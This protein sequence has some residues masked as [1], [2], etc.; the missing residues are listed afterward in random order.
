MGGDLSNAP[1]GVAP[2]FLIR[3]LRDP[4]G[5]NLDRVQ[6]VKGWLNAD[7]S[8]EERVLLTSKAP[9]FDDAGRVGDVVTVDDT[10]DQEKMAEKVARYDLL[11]IPVVDV[12][13]RLLGIVTVDDVVD[14][15]REEA[16]HSL[17]SLAGLDEDEDTFAPV[18]RSAPRRAIWLGI[19]LVSN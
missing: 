5:A 6:M 12:Q 7:G 19:N 4:D 11:A 17:M 15:I 16:D 9:L 10:D 14:V 13:H 1:S 18:V 3:A 8:T 2:R